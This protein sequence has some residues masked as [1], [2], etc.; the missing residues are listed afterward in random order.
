M[1]AIQVKRL[2]W[3]N[4]K[5]ERLKAYIK[6]HSLIMSDFDLNERISNLPDF[7][8]W[9]LTPER[10]LVNLFID[11]L[12]WHGDVEIVGKG[13]LPNEDIVFILKQIS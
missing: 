9:G 4:T 1:K 10:V 8:A 6:G 5:P 11:N 2:P 13:V 12:G 3:T 7:Q